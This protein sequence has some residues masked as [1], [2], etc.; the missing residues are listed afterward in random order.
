MVGAGTD[1]QL[2]SA[3]PRSP[4]SRAQHSAGADPPRKSASLPAWGPLDAERLPL[5]N[6]KHSLKKSGRA[7]GQI[8]FKFCQQRA[9]VSRAARKPSV[10]RIGQRFFRQA[11]AFRS[12]AAA[13]SYG[14]IV[15][16]DFG[17]GGGIG[18]VR[19][20]IPAACLGRVVPEATDKSQHH[21]PN[22]NPSG[23]GRMERHK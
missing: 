8:E 1:D 15:I 20:P 16:Q 22:H 7:L 18:M 3:K 9:P 19:Q 12:P 11:S 13:G 6:Q 21:R 23:C 2:P 14:G 5:E 10:G 4:A 17:L